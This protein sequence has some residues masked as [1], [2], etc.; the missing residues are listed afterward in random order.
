MFLSLAPFMTPNDITNIFGRNLLDDMSQL[1]GFHELMSN[2]TK[3]FECVADVHEARA[4]MRQLL[5]SP[6]W[7]KHA[8]VVASHGLATEQLAEPPNDNEEFSSTAFA[9]EIEAFLGDHP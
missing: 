6:L 2:E 7:S 1:T 8:V 3:P 5:S 4:S 9:H